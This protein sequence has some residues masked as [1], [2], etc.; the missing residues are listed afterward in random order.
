MKRLLFLT[1]LVFAGCAFN[2]PPPENPAVTRSMREA[3]G[4]SASPE[5]QAA[6]YLRTAAESTPGKSDAARQTYNTA[7]A[8]LAVLLR[9]AEGGRLWNHSFS[10][11][12]GADAYRVHFQPGDA[13]GVWSPGYFTSLTL[14]RDVAEKTVKRR[15][16]QEGIGGALVG[17]R[18][19]DPREPFAPRVG[20][21]APVTATVDFHGHDAVLT[22]HDP[23][24]QPSARVAGAV[25]PLEADFSAPLS[26]YPTINETWLGLMG[27]MHASDFMSRTG[28]YL[29]QP[30][31]PNR[32]PLIFVHG[33]I[34]TP[35]MWRNV[36]NEL[37]MDPV[38]RGRYQC[39]VFAYPT[40]N[41]YAYSALRFR[42]ELEKARKLYGFPHGMVVVGHSMG[43]LVTHIQTVTLTRGDWERVIGQPA[44]TVLETLPPD[45]TVH[46]S[47]IFNANPDIRR[48]VY[49][50]TPHRGSEMALGWIGQVGM[51]LISLPG[52]LAGTFAQSLG[53]EV[54]LVTGNAKLMPNGVTCLSPKNPTLKVMNSAPIHTP[55]HSIIGDQGKGDS[56]KSSDG[57]VPYWSSHLDGAQSEKI[58]PGPHGSCE[59]PQTIEE[60]KRILELHL[61]SAGAQARRS[62]RQ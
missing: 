23:S 19:K 18:K 32:I 6:L 59:L 17:V 31:D 20:V 5:A 2:A 11:G 30:Y 55:Y 58:V 40:G 39:W 51:R 36:I 43:G 47:I 29:L 35:Q 34:S 52:A 33:L 15:N 25:R 38:L 54:G 37:E 7:A 12:V 21:T 26:Y 45:G 14:A 57:V 42:E 28:L 9:T 50:C 27:A 1:V 8:E 48:V 61:N 53:H 46:R 16:L 13:H 44:K 49:I 24:A 41:P 4:K 3:R 10:V 60:L 62:S 56:P 22:L